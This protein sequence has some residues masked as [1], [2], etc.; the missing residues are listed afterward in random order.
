VDEFGY[1]RTKLADIERYE[2]ARA[3]RDR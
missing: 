2:S 1:L 3:S